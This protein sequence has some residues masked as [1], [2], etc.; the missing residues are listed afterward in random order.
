MSG[1]TRSILLGIVGFLVVCIIGLYM[2]LTPDRLRRILVPVMEQNLDRKVELNEVGLSLWGGVAASASGLIIHDRP[3]FGERPFLSAQNARFSLAFWP[4]LSG[5]AVLGDIT[6]DEP[7]ISYVVNEQGVSNIDDMM[8]GGEGEGGGTTVLP[9]GAIRI[10]KGSFSY[11][12]RR[13]GTNIN[14]L[15]IGYTVDLDLT[16]DGLGINGDLAVASVQSGGNPPVGPFGLAHRIRMK[17]DAVEIEQLQ[18]RAFGLSADL[19]GRIG[20]GSDA[21]VINLRLAEQTLDLGD[22]TR[23]LP[24]GTQGPAISGRLSLAGS[25]DGTW[26]PEGSP[27]AYPNLSLTLT[28]SDLSAALPQV[29]IPTVLKRAEIR[30][31]NDKVSLNRF[32][33]SAGGSDIRITGTVSGAVPWPPLPEGATHRP[34]IDLKLASNVFDV[35]EIAPPISTS[36]LPVRWSFTTPAWGAGP[37]PPSP[38]PNIVRSLDGTLRLDVG[39]LTSEAIVYANFG[40]NVV[41]RNNRLTVRPMQATLFGGKMEGWAEIDIPQ[42][43]TANRF[44][45]KAELNLTAVQA[46]EL[47]KDQ[48]NWD[49]PLSG[50]GRVIVK[51]SGNLDH[52]LEA[53]PQDL[54][55][56]GSFAF[57][58]GRLTNW[59][60]LKKATSGVGNL[61][62]LSA[63][64]ISV[65]DIR[66]PFRV[67][68]GRVFLSKMELLADRMPTRISGSGSLDGSLDFSLDLDV[69]SSRLNVGGLNVSG[70]ASA[71]F[72][73][74]DPIIPVR[75]KIG[76]TTDKPSFGVT[77]QPAGKG[78]VDR[79]KEAAQQK[80]QAE[81]DYTKERAK[82]L[83]EAEKEKTEKKVEKEVKKGT[84]KAKDLLKRKLGW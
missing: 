52:A 69:P 45:F 77:M 71:L 12:D 4:L 32:E 48:M 35:D 46:R 75:I 67:E 64:T 24:T 63:D 20:L 31:D 41:A 72:G 19:T 73:G 70:L 6:I 76:G 59:A 34:Q 38:I 30:I 37:L 25:V 22:L 44:P 68:N 42:D 14:V 18:P 61:S 8:E 79:Q 13:D 23:L 57:E 81:A 80:I 50:A 5:E 7:S 28:A 83:I 55:A 26:N 74:R 58:N 82:Q 10:R 29:S 40:A 11:I 84:E 60:L 43:T 49:L 17:D 33:V 15:G 51:A 78:Q 39:K 54:E 3:G 66:S 27:S 62:F 56:D 9:A 47:L 2:Y 1:K 21:P 65:K 53:V 16:G 36:S